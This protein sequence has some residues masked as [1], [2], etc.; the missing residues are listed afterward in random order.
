MYDPP[1]VEGGP[2]PCSR[3]QPRR[4][5]T[6]G[7]PRTLASVTLVGW[8][9]P[10]VRWWV[11]RRVVTVG[12]GQRRAVTTR[13]VKAAYSPDFGGLGLAQI[14]RDVFPPLVGGHGPIDG[15]ASSFISCIF[16]PPRPRGLR[17]RG[18]QCEGLASP[19][20][21][22]WV[23]PARITT[24]LAATSAVASTHGGEQSVRRP[25]VRHRPVSSRA[26]PPSRGGVVVAEISGP[27]TWQVVA[28]LPRQQ[29][30]VRL[31]PRRH[32]AHG[33]RV[34]LLCAAAACLWAAGERWRH[35]HGRAAPF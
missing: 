31:A 8:P 23:S 22:S 2:P 7:S 4:P 15:H 17:R 16:H 27:V 18:R 32:P 30:R 28:R 5:L 11:A 33:L 1:P 25:R 35:R 13:A 34:M 10:C 24:I 6:P 26:G 12:V 3:T 14:V 21:P 9:P 19:P 20:S 29:Q